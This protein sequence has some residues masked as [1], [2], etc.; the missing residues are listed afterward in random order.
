[1]SS[2][3][4]YCQNCGPGYTLKCGII[5][6]MCY[7]CGRLYSPRTVNIKKCVAAI[8][9]YVE[10]EFASEKLTSKRTD[11]VFYVDVSNFGTEDA[12]VFIK[13]LKEILKQR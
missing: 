12:D 1:M 4:V 13:K 6:G 3:E 5:G 7:Q 9:T 2:V 8:S 10:D 11:K